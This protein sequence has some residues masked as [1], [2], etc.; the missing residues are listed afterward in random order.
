MSTPNGRFLKGVLLALLLTLVKIS[1][2]ADYFTNVTAMSAVRQG[3]SSVLLPNGKAMM[4]GGFNGSLVVTNGTET[5][6]C[7]NRSWTVAGSLNFKRGYATA[8]LLQNGKVL[9]AGGFRFISRSML[10]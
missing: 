6:D 3:H 10:A 5:Y 9:V 2:R 7:T 8:T 4:I 1:A